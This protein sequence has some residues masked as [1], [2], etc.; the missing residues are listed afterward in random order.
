MACMYRVARVETPDWER[1][2]AVELVHQPWLE[3]CNISAEAKLCHDGEKLYVR[4][5]AKEKAIRATLTGMLDQVCNDSCLEFFFAPKADDKRYFNFEINPLGTAYVGFGAER[6][7]RVR[8]ILKNVQATLDPRP[9]RTDDGW[10]VEITV[11]AAYIRLYMPEF[12]F[13]GEAAANFYKCGDET[14]KPHYL[15]WAPLSSEKPDYHRRQDFGT[16]IFE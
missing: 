2:E 12:A 8:Q 4:M 9:Y 15:A 5:E 1:I 11:P 3:P 16:L 10:G 14:E 13:E 7:T 6:K